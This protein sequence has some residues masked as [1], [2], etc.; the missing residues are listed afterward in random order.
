MTIFLSEDYMPATAT[1]PTL[2]AWPARRAGM[3][4]DARNEA[5]Y[6]SRGNG[7]EQ[8]PDTVF[9]EEDEIERAARGSADALGDDQAARHSNWGAL[10]ECAPE[11]GKH[12]EPSKTVSDSPSG[13]FV[14]AVAL[15]CAAVLVGSLLAKYWH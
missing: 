14:V 11:S 4:G 13:W 6:P 5:F 8:E 2:F 12:R 7:T 10:S 3:P 1:R 9:L 15:C